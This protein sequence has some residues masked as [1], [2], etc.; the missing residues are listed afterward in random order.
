MAMRFLAAVVAAAL[1]CSAPT[2]LPTG[3]GGT[4]NHT[5]SLLTPGRKLMLKLAATISADGSLSETVSVLERGEPTTLTTYGGPRVA[6]S[7]ATGEQINGAV[8]WAPSLTPG[9]TADAPSLSATGTLAIKGRPAVPG[10]NASVHPHTDFPGGDYKHFT[11]PAVITPASACQAACEKETHS[12]PR[13]VGWTW[14]CPGMQGAKPVCWLK[15]KMI[16]PAKTDCATSGTIGTSQPAVPDAILKITRTVTLVA[17][18][19]SP[20]GG[21][22]RVSHSL[23]CTAGAACSFVS[24]EDVYDAVLGQDGAAGNGWAGELPDFVW[25]QSIK[26][27][28]QDIV[29]HWNFKNPGLIVQE[30]PLLAALVADLGAPGKIA[31]GKMKAHPQLLDLHNPTDLRSPANPTMSY[32]LASSA[33]RVHSIYSRTPTVP[34]T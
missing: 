26:E 3:T 13:C 21:M 16:L 12:T 4:A 22:V 10:T 25:S 14:A 33:Y 27:G 20:S 32:G 29:P 6:L 5:I 7:G 2:A 31:K 34:V 9:G 23:R 8:R 28:P 19:N 11:L 15:E 30:G 1:L 17:A 24:F 18:T